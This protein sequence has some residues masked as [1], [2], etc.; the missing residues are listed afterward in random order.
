M[1]KILLIASFFAA[2]LSM[3]AMVITPHRAKQVAM[4]AAEG[5]ADTDL[6]DMAVVYTAK[7]AGKADF[8]VINKKKGFVI[9]SADDVIGETVLGYS[10][11]GSF[12]YDDLPEN[13]KWWLS[14]YQEQIEQVRRGAVSVVSGKVPKRGI[15]SG[16]ATEVVVPPLLGDIAWGQSAPF[17]KFCPLID[18]SPSVTGCVATAMAQVM[19]FHNWPLQGVG[20]HTYTDSNKNTYTANFAE[21]TYEWY[22]IVP[23]YTTYTS[24]QGAAVARLMVDC[25]MSVNMAYNGTS[26]AA[27]GNNS[28]SAFKNFFDY[29]TDAASRSRST[30]SDKQW[31]NILKTEL[32][33][34]RPVI[35]GGSS[36]EGAHAFV[37][38]GYTSDG[39]FHFNFGWS[40]TGN[41]YFL[42][43]VADKYSK[44]Q[45][46]RYG[47]HPRSNLN[48]KY[49]DGL[50]YNILGNGEVAV[51]YPNSK[52]E[53]S[54]DIE[55][56]A[57]V[58]ISGRTYTVTRIGNVAFA[59]CEELTSVS[60]PSTV[61]LIGG[62]AFFGC[63]NLNI[64]VPWKTPLNAYYST[65][66]DVECNTA[67]LTVPQGAVDSYVTAE[68]W[69][70]FRII[71]DGSATT[72]DWGEWKPF[73]NGI[74]TY[75]H[76]AYDDK[77]RSSDNVTVKIRQ[78]KSNTN[79]YQVL[80]ENVG[81]T[82]K[83]A[84]TQ[85]YVVYSYG[86]YA[87]T[88]YLD[89]S[90][91]MCTVPK[92]VIGNYYSKGDMF[93]SDMP[94]YKSTYTYSKYPCKYNPDDCTFT[95]YLKY[96]YK[97]STVGDGTDILTVESTPKDYELTLTPSSVEEQDDE[98]GV[99]SFDSEIGADI[100]TV[101]YYTFAI[102][103]TDDLLAAYVKKIQDGEVDYTELNVNDDNRFNVTYPSGGKYTTVMC[104]FNT[105]GTPVKMAV[106]RTTYYP[107]ANWVSLGKATYT[108]DFV[109]T[110]FPNVD[111]YK[112]QVEVEQNTRFPGRYRIKNPYG[113]AYT[114]NAKG[115]LT[116]EKI[117]AYLQINAENPTAIYLPQ[118]QAMN[119]TLN[120]KTVG[121]MIVSSK[122]ADML[123]DGKTLAEA[124]AAGVCGQFDGCAITFPAKSLTV[125]FPVKSDQWSDSN[126][127]G[128]F[129]L[130]L[131][132][133]ID[134]PTTDIITVPSTTI[135][136][137]GEA[138]MEVQF[139]SGS[140]QFVSFQC[141]M[142]LPEGITPVTDADGKVVISRDESLSD[143][144][145]VDCERQ[146]DGSYRFIVYSPSNVQL[147]D[148]TLFTFGVTASPVIA[149]GTYQ[150]P[151]TGI[152]LVASD[153]QKV[154]ADDVTAIVT[155]TP[156]VGID[157]MDAITVGTSESY[158]LQ[159]L[160]VD[161]EYKGI[162]IRG[163]KKIL[164][165]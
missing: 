121:E 162:I 24:A 74:G 47:I 52:A 57:T 72:A 30:T 106:E 77:G 5:T 104:G 70:K 36:D 7:T 85:G 151:I 10:D 130:D 21:S 20:S 94:T 152:T 100:V 1:R 141:D 114:P 145:V 102:P 76:D 97:S 26:G 62:N 13:A 28:V 61:K 133:L 140:Q 67:T 137:N 127:E 136:T 135:E 23:K 32:D 99:Q 65:F 33:N 51:T 54:G 59:G 87:L 163:G 17:N 9:V 50:Y 118:S 55:I 22:N 91:N 112:Y 110:A 88:F 115:S 2:V 109:P 132:G 165:R 156:S 49:A 129:R 116:T 125:L 75:H 143:D 56:P 150:I 117:D 120:A 90:T 147:A 153:L 126:L 160:K 146:G 68:G 103:I 155:V 123:A 58:N 11:T 39:Y 15:K 98:T 66:N 43:T 35:Y 159:G 111:Q 41:G 149:V 3:H 81:I 154:Y 80:A 45:N 124:K 86:G 71:T 64:I 63:K 134:Q 42:S 161:D 48:R 6:N 92:Q 113:K 14:Q 27:F 40:G 164:Q 107:Q 96:Y 19:S 158:N 82:V 73:E 84:S 95:L 29:S 131:T 138:Q 34:Y 157:A 122:A 139:H 60:I 101:R 8:Y 148:G 144:V 31:D 89:M 128:T 83:E 44:N 4:A 37:T 78:S 119:V 25:G 105:E 53:Y 16:T 142:R 93:V 46:I 79:M 18:G 108:D 38:D 12:D 69:N